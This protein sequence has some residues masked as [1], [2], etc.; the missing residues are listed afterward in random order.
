MLL[1]F[2]FFA[3]QFFIFTLFCALPCPARSGTPTQVAHFR[4]MS[5]ANLQSQKVAPQTGLNILMGGGVSAGHPQQ[6]QSMLIQP[7]LQHSASQPQMQSLGN[8]TPANGNGAA[9]HL[10]HST[11]TPQLASQGQQQPHLAG[12]VFSNA[13]IGGGGAS[14]SNPANGK[15]STPADKD[16]A[17]RELQAS[18]LAAAGMVAESVSLTKPSGGTI[19]PHGGGGVGQVLQAPPSLHVPSDLAATGVAP[20]TPPGIQLDGMNWNLLGLDGCGENTS[21]EIDTMELDILHMFDPEREVEL[22]Q[23]GLD[24]EKNPQQ[25]G[26]AD[27]TTKTS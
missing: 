10:P 7:T 25:G 21:G 14:N 26:T 23:Q 17:D 5:P 19:L 2:I 15:R 1:C 9:T 16:L 20:A 6:Q 13:A 18:A 12:G 11:S 8:P 24:V 4:P 22:V 27:P 3:F